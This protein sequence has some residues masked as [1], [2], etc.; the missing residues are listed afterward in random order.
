[1]YR[2]E[3]DRKPCAPLDAFF[4]AAHSDRFAA[5]GWLN[6]LDGLTNEETAILIRDVPPA[7]ISDT[8]ARFALQLVS[9]NKKNL[10]LLKK[11]LQ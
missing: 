4:E 1:M 6:V 2:A 5:L 7:R 3:T 11:E 9:V 10:L 8:A